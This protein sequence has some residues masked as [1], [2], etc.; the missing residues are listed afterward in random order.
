MFFRLATTTAAAAVALLAQDFPPP[1]PGGGFPGGGPPPFG[2]GGFGPPGGGEV[3]LVKEFDKDGNGYLDAIERKAAREKLKSMPRR[4]PGGGFGGRRGGPFGGD[5]AD[6]AVPKAGLKLTPDQVKKYGS[7]P[8]YDPNV[9]RTVFLEFDNPDWE[10]EMADFNNTDVDMP[11]NMTVDG[12]LYKGVGV[13]FRG[14]SS[15]MMVPAG[16]KRSLNVSVDFLNKE[17]RLDGYRTLNLLNSHGDPTF[18]RTVMYLDI[19]RK[20]IPAP[21][22]NFMRVVINGESWGIYTSQEQFNSDFV[23]EWFPE[24]GGARWK[25]SGSPMGQG[26]LSYLGEDPAA[27]KKIYEI[28]SKDSKKDWAALINLT[29]VLT[30]TPIDQL[31]QALQPILDIDGTLKFLALEKAFV[32]SDGYW[33]RSSDYSIYLDAK[34]K[35]HVIPHDANET[36]R[37]PEGGPGMRGM[38]GM[39]NMGNGTELDPFAGSQDSKRV[40]ISRLLAVPALRTRYL[41]YMRDIAEKW[42]TWDKL[43]PMA[44]K[45]QKLIAADVK[46]DTRK[47]DSF[48]A[49]ENGVTVDGEEDDRGFRRP[50]AAP[51]M[52]MKTFVEGRRKFLL[53]YKPK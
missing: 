10:A 15:F 53:A 46:A 26:G 14:M 39:G 51:A 21:K 5:N 18:L 17:Q 48:E 50:G 13:H 42:M 43:G 33:I 25:V 16:R 12:K 44:A 9:L 52:S 30:E 35:F 3:K 40:L 6:N 32:N 19:A 28:K 34:G 31:E 45:Y 1:P 37:P 2:R 38:G 47:L 24:G 7:E 8:L 29:K 49:F 27:Y 4:G 20:Y 36:I 11:V 23:K 41:A 22:A